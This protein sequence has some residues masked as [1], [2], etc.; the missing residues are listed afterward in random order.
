MIADSLHHLGLNFRAP[1]VAGGNGV[2]ADGEDDVVLGIEGLRD[3]ARQ[4]VDVGS[5]HRVID[6]DVE[7]ANQQAGAVVM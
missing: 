7:R 3:F 1:V 5:A 2:D 4:L 6:V